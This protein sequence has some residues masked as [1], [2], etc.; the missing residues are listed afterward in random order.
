MDT[1]SEYARE[2]EHVHHESERAQEFVVDDYSDME[3][4]KSPI[5][6]LGAADVESATDKLV[7]PY[8]CWMSFPRDSV[9]I[10]STSCGS[11][12]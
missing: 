6:N 10:Y 9:P 5:I 11:T 1:D 12:E 8:L 4:Y 7:M 3:S 2:R